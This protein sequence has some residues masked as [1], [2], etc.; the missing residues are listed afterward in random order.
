M[1]LKLSSIRSHIR[2]HTRFQHACIPSLCY[3]YHAGGDTIF[4]LASGHGRAGISVIRLSGNQVP[5]VLQQITK[6]ADRLISRPRL[7]QT[8]SILDYPTV[9]ILDEGMAVFFAGP[10]SFTGEHSA[11]LHL[12][13]SPAVIDATY[14]LLARLGLRLANPGE[15]SQRALLNGKL[16]LDQVEALAD[17]IAAQTDQQRKQA[18]SGLQAHKLRAQLDSWRLGL[19]QSLARIEAWIDFS[20]D[21]QI[22]P[23]DSLHSAVDSLR[24]LKSQIDSR[25][26]KDRD[27]EIV[28]SGLK[29]V[30][31][32]PPNAGKSSLLNRLAG[33]KAAIVSPVPGT[34]RDLIRV[35]LSIEGL[36]VSVTDTAGLR[37]TSDD[38]EAA[39]IDLAKEAIAQAHIVLYL[40]DHLQDS[41][42][43]RDDLDPSLDTRGLLIRVQSKCDTITDRGLMGSAWKLS[44]VDDSIFESFYTRLAH[45]VKDRCS[46]VLSQEDPP[47][48][49]RARH[50]QCLHHA[51][52][53]I[54]RALALLTCGNAVLGAEE[55]RTATSYI[56]QITGKA[57]DHEEVLS[58]LFSSFCIGK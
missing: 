19:V 39:G 26:V 11:E 4:A 16:G 29:V 17:L 27:A 14:G 30:I 18:L 13:G 57:I 8:C 7:L 53:S 6:K 58:A 15:F 38:V 33:R 35:D 9:S 28:R 3:C 44:S 36:H 40:Q 54:D 20:E 34:T 21:E 45:L 23:T 24:A 10:A 55:L 42:L 48:V 56:G 46:S 31:A 25:L 32:G 49:I 37:E 52:T 47:L 2:S 41:A 12:H 22:D 51:S 1:F 43:H 50:R 5:A